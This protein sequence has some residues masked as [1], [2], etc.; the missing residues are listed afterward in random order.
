MPPRAMGLPFAVSTFDVVS[1]VSREFDYR[2]AVAIQM[3]PRYASVWT[4]RRGSPRPT[5]MPSLRKK[6]W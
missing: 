1:S 5:G 4:G 6:T 2:W 3:H